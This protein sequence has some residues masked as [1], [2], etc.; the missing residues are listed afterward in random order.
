MNNK[1]K[2]KKFL[3]I[4]V[5]KDPKFGSPLAKLMIWYPT[6]HLW[7]YPDDGCSFDL[8]V[9]ERLGLTKDFYNSTVEMIG[10]RPSSP[11]YIAVFLAPTKKY[12]KNRKALDKKAKGYKIYNE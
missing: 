1:I 8:D 6:M 7:I 12:L 10:L 2:L 5:N 3:K 4:R 11:D 9:I